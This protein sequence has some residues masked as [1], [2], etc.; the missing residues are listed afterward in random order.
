MTHRVEK[1]TNG[2]ASSARLASQD[3]GV[4]VKREG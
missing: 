1:A 3:K 2:R 4:A